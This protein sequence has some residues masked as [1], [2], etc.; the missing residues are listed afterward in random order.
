MDDQT[1]N[2]INRYCSPYSLLV[3]TPTKLIR[4]HCPFVVMVI[5]PVGDLKPEQLVKVSQV[6]TTK[7]KLLVYLI[8]NKA[9]YYYHFSILI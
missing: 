9:Y 8:D 5:I 4:L 1:I 3:H 2:E 7:D 6:K